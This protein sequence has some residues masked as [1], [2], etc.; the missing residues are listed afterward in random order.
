[1][2]RPT[3][4]AALALLGI[5]VSVGSVG[6]SD[7]Y[8]A[9]TDEESAPTATPI[10][11]ST[12]SDA[13]VSSANDSNPYRTIVPYTEGAPSAETAPQSIAPPRQTAPVV[14]SPVIPDPPEQQKVAEV[15]T[16]SPAPRTADAD[17]D[18]SDEQSA[19]PMFVPMA[20]A[21]TVE[22]VRNAPMLAP[23][24]AKVREPAPELP[25]TERISSGPEDANLR[26]EVA[27]RHLMDA[28]PDDIEPYFDLFLYVSKAGSGP[29]GQHMFVFQRDADGKIVPYAEWRVSTGREKLILHHGRKVRTNTPEGIFMLDPKRFYP[30]YWSHSWNN[31]PMHYAMFYDLMTNGRQS[32]IAIH[33][34]IGRSKINRLGRRDSAGCI[35]LSPRNA[36]ELFYKVQNTTR[37]QVP[38]LAVN[39]RNSTDRWGKAERT[40]GGAMVLQ[41]GYRALLYVENFD[42]RQETVGPVV[43]YTH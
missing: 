38:V 42:G 26:Y 8:R 25:V 3:R 10:V 28:V 24:R 22:A 4:L 16:T 9:R 2:A 39:A 1:M 6:S 11:A 27:T 7:P 18:D 5:L 12:D 37:G 29:L 23:A 21:P 40:E 15:A 20:Q 41:D 43:A 34:A 32:G 33:A 30:R 17:V 13:A 36:K 31:A 14:M 35:R 19:T